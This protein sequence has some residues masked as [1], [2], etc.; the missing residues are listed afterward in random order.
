MGK[1][2]TNEPPYPQTAD[3]VTTYCTRLVDALQ[4]YIGERL[5]CVL[6]CGSWAR[7]EAQPP[8]SDTDVTVIVD[9]V[10]ATILPGLQAAWQAAEMGCANVY[11]ADEVAI[12]SHEA[13]EMYT[14]NAHVVWGT[15]PFPTR[16]LPI[17]GSEGGSAT[18]TRGSSSKCYAATRRQT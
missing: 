9:T 10:D 1:R 13:L 7:G 15:N 12:M 6:L 3:E 18:I 14:T 5:T 2:L 17:V 8:T 16:I 4:T 11:G